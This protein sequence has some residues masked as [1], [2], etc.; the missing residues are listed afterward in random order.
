MPLC[1]KIELKTIRPK[2]A[3]LRCYETKNCEPV[4]KISITLIHRKGMHSTLEQRKTLLRAYG[5]NKHRKTVR[6]KRTQCLRTPSK[7]QN[8]PRVSSHSIH[9]E[10]CDSDKP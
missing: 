6:S 7:I 1:S 4:S 9:F 5:K 8:K 2:L 3:S 10:N